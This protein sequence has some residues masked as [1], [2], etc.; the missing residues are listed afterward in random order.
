MRILKIDERENFLHI[1]PEIED[2]LWH[3]E[4]VI[5]KHDLVSGQSDRK[6]KPKEAGEKPRRVKMFIE[7][8]ADNVEFHR[9]LGQLR[10]SGTITGGKPAELLEIGSQQALEIEIGRDIKIKKKALKKYQIE[11]LKK[12]SEATKKGKT[13]GKQ[14]TTIVGE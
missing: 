5:E 7:L 10:V 6:I 4:R 13:N 2:D 8:D 1:V 14:M 3:L 12:A 9:F 11:R